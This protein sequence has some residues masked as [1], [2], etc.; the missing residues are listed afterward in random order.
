MRESFSQF[1]LYSNSIW[2]EYYLMFPLI[3]ESSIDKTRYNEYLR[4]IGDI[5]LKRYNAYARVQSLAIAFRDEEGRTDVED[6]VRAYAVEVN[7]VSAKID[8]WLRDLYCFPNQ[9]FSAEGL[10]TD[11]DFNSYNT[12]LKVA[13]SM[14]TLKARAEE[15]STLM[16]SRLEKGGANR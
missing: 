7:G 12:F 4:D 13:Q 16:V 15:V 8:V 14:Q 5:K 9:C 2:E 10:G 6:S 1:L 11:I 3:Q